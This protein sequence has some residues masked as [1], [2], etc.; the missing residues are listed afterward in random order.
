MY[1]I[2]T[3]LAN[4]MPASAVVCGVFKL[5]T[6]IKERRHWDISASERLVGSFLL[7]FL[8]NKSALNAVDTFRISS[9]SFATMV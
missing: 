8:F 4:D 6:E 7:T 5:C 9:R 2:N 1:T 3:V